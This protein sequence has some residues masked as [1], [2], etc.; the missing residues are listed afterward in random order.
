MYKIL[1]TIIVAFGFFFQGCTST[2]ISMRLE[3]QNPLLATIDKCHMTLPWH[4][5]GQKEHGGP[6]DLERRWYQDEHGNVIVFES[7]KLDD[8][9]EFVVGDASVMVAGFEFTTYKTL[10]HGRHHTYVEGIDR[11]GVPIYLLFSGIGLQ[12][13]FALLYAKN[14]NALNEVLI[15][16]DKDNEALFKRERRASSLLPLERL[17]TYIQSDWSA[18]ML[19]RHDIVRSKYVD[20][21]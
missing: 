4:L 21:F 18:G 6:I 13:D 16:L 15:C 1:F 5:V 12:Q 20:T 17:E 19:F 7:A 2:Q 3:S 8:P 11:E 14:K 10:W 9:G